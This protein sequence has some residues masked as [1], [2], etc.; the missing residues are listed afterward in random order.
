MPP[1]NP[2]PPQ[3]AFRHWLQSRGLKHAWVANELGY[4]PEYFSRVLRGMT[5]L[6]AEFRQRCADRLSLPEAAWDKE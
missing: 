6:T 1:A 3:T 4:T 5:P 2:C